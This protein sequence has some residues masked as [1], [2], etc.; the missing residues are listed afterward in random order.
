LGEAGG[1]GTERAQLSGKRGRGGGWM[2]ATDAGGLK[3]R[4]LSDVEYV[5]KGEAEVC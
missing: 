3:E 4:K 5:Y 2:D 1:D